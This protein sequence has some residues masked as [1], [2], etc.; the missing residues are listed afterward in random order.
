M[1]D[2]AGRNRLTPWDPGWRAFTGALFLAGFAT[3]NLIFAPQAFLPELSSDLRI[4]AAGAAVVV[5]ATALGVAA[6]VLPWAA[7]SDRIGRMRSMR[8]S[9]VLAF[10][11]A[12]AVPF[13]P[14]FETVVAARGVEGLLLAATPAIGMAY[15]AERVDGRWAAHVAGTFV[16]GNTIGGIVGR[17]ASGVASDVGGWRLAFATST[18]IAAGSITAF[19]VLTRARQDAVP[20][21]V[22]GS[23]WSGVMTNLRR[24]SMVA[25]YAQG[26]LLMGAFGAIYNMFGYRL[27]APPLAVPAS[28]TSLVFIAYLAG[29]FASRRSASLARRIGSKR[30]LI[31]GSLAMLA[32]LPLMAI[33]SIPTMIAGLLVFT[34]GCFTAHPLA[35]GLSGRSARGARSQSTAFYQI[36]WLSGTSVFGWLGGVVYAGAGWFATLGVVAVLCVLAAFIATVGIDE[37][38]THDRPHAAG[39]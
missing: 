12:A 13:L 4:D 35:S 34:V 10:A 30:A 29:T 3:F 33:S 36:A 15:I 24:P 11:V 32:S 26:L 39:E 5:S 27:Q 37:T 20:G 22:A 38:S 31:A 23:A 16:A 19:L 8:M 17:L 14:T 9:L 7:V 21:H 25:L 2:G 6:G 28:I 1:P 18:V